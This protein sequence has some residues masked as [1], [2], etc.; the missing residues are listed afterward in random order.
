MRRKKRSK[1]R[2]EAL[3]P[4]GRKTGQKKK[5]VNSLRNLKTNLQGG[6]ADKLALCREKKKSVIAHTTTIPQE[7]N[8]WKFTL[9]KGP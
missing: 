9:S 2:P 8:W 3:S 7:D 6:A 4:G 1:E 5:W